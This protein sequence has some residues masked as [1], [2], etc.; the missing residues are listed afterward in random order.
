MEQA[1]AK[2]SLTNG[3]CSSVTS[4]TSQATATGDV[5]STPLQQR[6]GH[7]AR[8][9]AAASLLMALAVLV[10]VALFPRLPEVS[11]ALQYQLDAPDPAYTLLYE[12][13]RQQQLEYHARRS[14]SAVE[15]LISNGMQTDVPE[16]QQMRLSVDNDVAKEVCDRHWARGLHELVADRLAGLKVFVAMN[17]HDNA[18]VA[19]HMTNQLHRLL[20][21]L[22]PENCFVSVYES[23]SHDTTPGL[24]IILHNLLSYMNV[25]HRII[26]SSGDVRGSKERI[27]FLASVRNKAIEPLIEPGSIK[28]DKV[29]FLNDVYNCAEDMLELLLH[30]AHMVSGWDIG[31]ID[32]GKRK[33]RYY[34]YWVGRDIDGSQM[35]M[36]YPWVESQPNRGRLDAGLPIPVY[37]T[38][39][40]MVAINAALFQKDKLRFRFRKWRGECSSSEMTHFCDDIW[41]KHKDDTRIVADPRVLVTYGIKEFLEVDLARQKKTIW[42]QISFDIGIYPNPWKPDYKPGQPLLQSF[43]NS[44]N[45]TDVP[46]VAPELVVCCP[47]QDGHSYANEGATCH[48]EPTLTGLMHE[49]PCPQGRCMPRGLCPDVANPGGGNTPVFIAMTLHEDKDV[50]VSL[51]WQIFKLAEKLGHRLHVSLIAHGENKWPIWRSQIASILWSLRIPSHHEHA[52]LDEDYGLMQWTELRTL[53]GKVYVFLVDPHTPFCA[54]H[55]LASLWDTTPCLPAVF[56]HKGQDTGIKRCHFQGKPC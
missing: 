22:K 49:D 56:T 50:P 13:T 18:Q 40:G 35:T 23:G 52:P 3:D 24:M 47:M 54:A 8:R 6:R 55:V 25:P 20:L 11:Q 53:C 37:C 7:I 42:R 45:Y 2:D 4:N 16:D 41:A 12:L 48:W 33:L 30:D 43:L 29:L 5:V 21:M 27:D 38:W 19:A 9:M 36:W 10:H 46:V 44:L 28:Y 15:P 34:D 14:L 31:N 17:L 1:V 51:G 32:W 26:G 39:N